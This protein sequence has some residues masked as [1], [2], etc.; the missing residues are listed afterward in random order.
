MGTPKLINLLKNTGT[1]T[2]DPCQRCGKLMPRRAEDV[3]SELKR[4]RALLM[5]AQDVLG[6]R[7]VL[8]VDQTALLIGL[9]DKAVIN[10]DDYDA[11]FSEAASP[12]PTPQPDR[13]S[14][15]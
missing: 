8:D 13:C 4:L 11:L 5:A 1:F 10:P 2:L 3:V 14:S 6:G 15:T 12:A 9:I 7:V